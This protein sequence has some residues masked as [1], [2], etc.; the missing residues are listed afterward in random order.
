MKRGLFDKMDPEQQ[1]QLRK[2]KSASLAAAAKFEGIEVEDTAEIL[3]P[4][5][6]PPS[7]SGNE[8]L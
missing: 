6:D 8:S 3:K 2:L 5:S 1:E 4:A 7:K